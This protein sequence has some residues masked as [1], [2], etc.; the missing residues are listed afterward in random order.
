[1]NEQRLYKNANAQY[2]H[3]QVDQVATP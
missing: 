1:L 2:K 3:Q